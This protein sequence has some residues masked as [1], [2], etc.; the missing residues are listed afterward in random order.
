METTGRRSNQ[1]DCRECDLWIATSPLVFNSPPV[2]SCSVKKKNALCSPR[3]RP[4][5]RRKIYFLRFIHDTSP[6]VQTFLSS[7]KPRSRRGTRQL[8]V[9][10]VHRYQRP[11]LSRGRDE[12]ARLWA[13]WWARLLLRV[14]ECSFRTFRAASRAFSG[15]QI[16]LAEYG[17]ARGGSR[18]I[19]GRLPY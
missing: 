7:R 8:R 10:A 9:C 15:A 1:R 17:L 13:Q 4:S 2:S 18:R 6:N 19:R 14:R 3:H 11:H 16:P 5:R 12:R